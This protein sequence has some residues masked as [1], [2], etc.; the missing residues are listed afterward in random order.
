[1]KVTPADRW[2]GMAVKQRD[3]WRCQRCGTAHVVGSR[4]LQAAHL[5]GRARWATRLDPRNLIS[6]CAA[7]H[8][9]AHGN[10]LDFVELMEKRL[11]KVA[12][13]ALKGRAQDVSLAKRARREASEIAAFYKSEYERGTCNSYFRGR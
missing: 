6:L 1:M 2:V 8:F 10:P 3:G 12:L 7:C 11:G 13:R 5:I 9:W 4:G